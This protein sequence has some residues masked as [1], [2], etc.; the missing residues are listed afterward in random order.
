M[1]MPSHEFSASVVR[2]LT[3]LVVMSALGLCGCAVIGPRAITAGRSVYANVINQTDDEQ[4]LNMIV[5][6]RYN[7]SSSLISVASITASL[8]FSSQIGTNIGIGSSDNYAGN[9]VPLS[10]GIAYEENPTISY[11]PLS[12]EDFM[13]RM[14]SPVSTREWLLLSGPAE[15]PGQVL[16]LA[17]D[18]INGLRGPRPGE[19]P[20]SPEFARFIELYD[21]LRRADVLDIVELPET[22]GENAFFADIHDYAG[23]YENNVREILDLLGIA[24]KPDGASILLPFRMAVGRSPSAIHVQTRSAYEVLQVFGAGIEIP[25]AHIEAGIVEPTAWEPPEDR[26][27]F[28]IRSSQKRPKNATVQIEVRDRW[29]YIDA[30]DTPSKRAFMFLRTFIAMRLAAPAGTQ[31]AP[32]LTVPVN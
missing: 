2:G 10:A 8:R 7:E 23:T 27:L 30:A 11:L 17:V 12:G 28:R 13:R 32:V 14:L 5:R 22:G 18:R 26:K 20:P 1:A 3:V 24:A 31:Q 4:I 21:R 9:L 16:A 19:G 25:P 29:F 15:H 6:M